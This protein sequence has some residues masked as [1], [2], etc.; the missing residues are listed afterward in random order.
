MSRESA[1]DNRGMEDQVA[2]LEARGFAWI[3]RAFPTA[4][5]AF[6]TARALTAANSSPSWLMAAAPC[7]NW[8]GVRPAPKSF[9]ARVP[10]RTAGLPARDLQ[11]MHE[12]RSSRRF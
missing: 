4:E 6:D 2:Q 11:A 9:R 7:A 1:G 8:R 12:L 5:E 3:R 10:G